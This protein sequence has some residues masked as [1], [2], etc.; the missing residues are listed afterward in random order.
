MDQRYLDCNNLSIISPLLK[1]MRIELYNDK[2]LQPNA[3]P[4]NTQSR[5]RDQPS[6]KTDFLPFTPHADI[7]ISTVAKLNGDPP[8]IPKLCQSLDPSSP[9]FNPFSIYSKI[10]NSWDKLFF[11][12][13]TLAGTMLQKWFLVQVDIDVSASL[14]H[15]YTTADVCYCYFLT[16]HPGDKN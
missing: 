12:K 4:L 5:H 6:N 9:P 13:Y 15:D 14:R 11:M 7:H 2:W 10:I 16:K 8:P 1:P 3:N